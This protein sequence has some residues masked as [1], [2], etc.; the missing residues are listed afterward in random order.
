MTLSELSRY[1]HN[2]ETYHLLAEIL[3]VAMV[4]KGWRRVTA[5]INLPKL[6]TA[7]PEAE[8]SENIGDAKCGPHLDLCFIKPQIGT[9]GAVQLRYCVLLTKQSI[10]SFI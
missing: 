4:S 6:S 3:H 1:H 9:Q 7:K 2:M 8:V 5:G 10:F